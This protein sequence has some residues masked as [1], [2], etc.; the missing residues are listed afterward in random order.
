MVRY[1]QK[2][3]ICKERWALTTPRQQ[4]V[5]TDCESKLLSKPIK[6]PK[7]KKM[8]NID[9]K[10]YENPFL[11]SIR[12]NYSRYGYLTERQVAAFKKVVE[13]LKNPKIKELSKSK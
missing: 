1:K 9:P 12:L 11:K 5:C 13:D 6:D 8:F 2:C 7:I 4:P 3:V 10:F